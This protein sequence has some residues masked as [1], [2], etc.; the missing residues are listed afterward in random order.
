MS[1]VSIVGVLRESCNYL[2][3]VGRMEFSGDFFFFSKRPCSEWNPR[4]CNTLDKEKA[5]VPLPKGTLWRDK[6]DVRSVTQSRNTSNYS[7]H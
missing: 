1:S 7:V 5:C 4:P 2:H 3:I 6:T